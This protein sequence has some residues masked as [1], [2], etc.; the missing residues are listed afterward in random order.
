MA[1]NRLTV[2]QHN[3][4]N[5][6]TQNYNLCNSYANIDPDIILINSHGC[7][8]N[9]TIKIFNF[10]VYQRNQ[11]EQLN[12]GVAI[13]VK[14]GLKH[15]IINNFNNEIMAVQITTTMGEVILSTAYLPP[16]RDFLP[17]EE[18]LQL[19]NRHLPV[20]LLG[21]LNARHIGLGHS[22]NNQV[23]KDLMSLIQ[24]GK[25]IHLGPHFSTF[26]GHRTRTRPDIVLTNTKAF[27]NYYIQQGPLTSSD[28]LPIIFTIT[29][30][31]VCATATPM[32]DRI[33]IAFI[34]NFILITFL[35]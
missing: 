11:S 25:A 20:Y 27:L 35:K 8:S 7:N 30:T 26:I 6:N 3:V 18:I 10:H 28:H 16:R 23:G 17:Y 22:N 15:R 14:K 13:A 29:V 2:I 5:W 32:N 1:Q 4:R 9:Q 24:T 12:D 33:E 19:M 21:D 34:R 31:T